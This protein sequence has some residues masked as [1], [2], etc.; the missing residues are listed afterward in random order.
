MVR[1]ERVEVGYDAQKAPKLVEIPSATGTL[2]VRNDL[3]RSF[4]AVPLKIRKALQRPSNAQDRLMLRALVPDRLLGGH[5][6]FY[7]AVI[8]NRRRAGR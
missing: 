3:Q 7:Y 2:Y 5:K 6:L 1:G 8:R 4:T